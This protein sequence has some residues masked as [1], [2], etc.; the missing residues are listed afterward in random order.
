M[1]FYEF[2]IDPDTPLPAGV[3]EETIRSHVE[4][5]D[6][7]LGDRQC[8]TST[9]KWVCTLESGHD[10]YHVACIRGNICA[11]WGSAPESKITTEEPGEAY[12][13]VGV[14]TAE[15]GREGCTAGG[16]RSLN[17]H[18]K[19]ALWNLDYSHLNPHTTTV[20]YEFM[21]GGFCVCLI[22]ISEND[23]TVSLLRGASRRSYKDK[24]NRV[25]GEM[26]AFVRALKYSR[27]I[28]IGPNDQAQVTGTVECVDNVL[29]RIMHVDDYDLD[30]AIREDGL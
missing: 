11:V 29:D 19:T 22:Q 8:G 14:V 12:K 16:F 18:E 15:C 17:S 7:L 1:S 6:C 23:S 26:K 27:P 4:R 20:S 24:Q 2:N 28:V 13:K 10:G 5:F 3:T 9:C 30:Q 25:S 21:Q